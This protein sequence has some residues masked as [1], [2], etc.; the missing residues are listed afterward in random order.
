MDLNLPMHTG[1]EVAEKFRERRPEY[2]TRIYAF[3]G[4]QSPT[5]G[6]AAVKAGMQGCFQKPF[7]LDELKA[8]LIE[9]RVL[10]WWKEKEDV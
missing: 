9:T 4:S 5:I 3:S 6:E 10:T 8:I 1:F 2:K 7:S